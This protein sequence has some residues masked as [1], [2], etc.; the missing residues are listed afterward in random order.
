MNARISAVQHRD[1]PGG[2]SHAA[3]HKASHVSERVCTKS[4]R[5]T[6]VRNPSSRL[7]T[8]KIPLHNAGDGIAVDFRRSPRELICPVWINNRRRV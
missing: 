7:I 1:F 3:E 2:E 5:K 8:I 4:L 6:R